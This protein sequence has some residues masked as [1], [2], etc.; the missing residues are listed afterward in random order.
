M[1]LQPETYRW[2]ADLL[3][4]V[5]VLFIAFAVLG[6]WLALRW[7]W[8]PWAHLPAACWS[9]FIELRGGICPLTPLENRLRVAAGLDEYSESFVERYVMPILYPSELTRELQLWLGLFVVTMNVAAYTA[10]WLRSRLGSC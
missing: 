4:G 9:A 6:G 7:R 10:V 3:V 5:H 1:D 8:L 2:L